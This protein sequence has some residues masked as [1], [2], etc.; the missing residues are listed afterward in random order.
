MKKIRKNCWEYQKCG[1]ETDG[2]N[3]AALGTCPAAVD[4]SFNGINGGKNGG[5]FCWAVAGTFCGG[6]RQ[7]TYAEKRTS[8]IDCSFFR[9]VQ[10]DEGTAKLTRKFLRFISHE[11]RSPYFANMT[12]RKIEAGTRFITQGEIDENAYI[13]EKGSCIVVVEK[14]GELHPVNHYGEGDIAGGLGIL[15]GEPR[16]AHV[17]AETDMEVWVLNKEQFMN[18]TE[19]DPEVLTFLT[20]VVADRF[21]SRRPTAYRTIGKYVASEIIGRGGY[22]IVYQGFH[23]S[24]NMPVAIKMMR[25]NMAMDM[26]FINSFRLEAQ[27]IAAMNHEN[28]LKIYDFEERYRT[29]FIIMEL[30]EGESLMNLLPRLTSLPVALSVK[31]LLQI[32]NGLEYAHDKGIIHRDINTD[33]IF[34]AKGDRVKILDFGLACP[35]GTEDLSFSGTVAYMAP[36]Q[37]NCHPVDPR[38]DIYAL[39]IVAYEM[40]TGKRPFPE[41]D[42]RCLMDFHLTHDI[43]DPAEVEPDLPMEIRQFIMT[44]GRVEMDKRYQ[45][46]AQAREELQP[47]AKKFGIIQ[48]DVEKKIL[49]KNICLIYREDQ[50]LHLSRRMEA[51]FADIKRMGVIT[52]VADFNNTETMNGN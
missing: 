41:T 50:Q 2:S 14:D 16:I 32:C 8:C 48:R 22:S 3:T 25:H 23:K 37:I 27:T 21:D 15:T 4:V 5:R 39:G 24:L 52:K 33:N 47:L 45:N 36:E 28:I 11:K 51:F 18:M 40:V 46:V 19:K 17:E 6:K 10:D 34:I 7:G 29:L 42:I 38:T 30:L 31:F 44:C 12:K 9:L 13:I 20:E 49:M 26:D 1:R 35:I 43:P